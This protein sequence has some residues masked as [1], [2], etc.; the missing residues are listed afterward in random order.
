[1]AG[2]SVYLQNIEMI[3]R[4]AERLGT[5]RSNLISKCVEDYFENKRQASQHQYVTDKKTLALGLLLAAVLVLQM[6]IVVR[7][8]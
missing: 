6:I 4:E 2:S 7:I 1:M 8:L 5:N 3:D